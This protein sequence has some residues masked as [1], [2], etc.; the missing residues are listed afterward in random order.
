MQVDQ[1]VMKSS[2]EI[3]IVYPLLQLPQLFRYLVSSQNLPYK[4]DCL[5]QYS[6]QITLIKTMWKFELPFQSIK[7]SSNLKPKSIS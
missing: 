3:A 5:S 4:L 6:G 2:L 7:L 1:T